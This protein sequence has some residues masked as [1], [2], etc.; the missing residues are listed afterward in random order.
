MPTKD[1][2]G[3]V[4]AFKGSLKAV[5]KL[6]KR[7]AG[8]NQANA[9]GMTPLCFAAQEGHLPI[10]ACLLKSGAAVNQALQ[11]GTTPLIIAAYKGTHQPR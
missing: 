6:L 9:D 1:F 11:D 2:R 7:G 3:L 10:V 4:A 8:V 5:R